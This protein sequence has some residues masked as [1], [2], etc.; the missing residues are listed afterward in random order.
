MSRLRRRS[1]FT[2]L[3]VVLAVVL[4]VL[5]LGGVLA[6][7]RFAAEAR[8]DIMRKADA[9]SAR[10]LIM[11]RI[12]LELQTAF[13]SSHDG[14]SLNGSWDRLSLSTA[15]MPKPS[16]WVVREATDTTVTNEQGVETVSYS[17]RTHTEDDETVVIDGL[18]RLSQPAI[19]QGLADLPYGTSS[20][21]SSEVKFVRFRF[22]DGAAW[23]DGWNGATLPMGV[24]VV[25]GAEPLPV[26]SDPTAYSTP[27]ARRVIF[28]P[29]GAA[30]AT[31]TGGTVRGLQ[32]GTSP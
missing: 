15:T 13:V 31:S 3:E 26:G 6:F 23:N 11:E 18:E 1:A 21:L 5:V 8:S 10:R 17:L 4:V 32:G 16:A 30:S 14:L 9:L 2:L 7:Y 25:L 29:G 24:E 27:I 28:V 22:W 20:L 12:T 19:T